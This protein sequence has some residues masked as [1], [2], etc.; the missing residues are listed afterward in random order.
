MATCGRMELMMVS[1]TG[2]DCGGSCEPCNDG[3]RF[4]WKLYKVDQ[5]ADRG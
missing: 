4:F 3:R 1:R 5:W 2:V